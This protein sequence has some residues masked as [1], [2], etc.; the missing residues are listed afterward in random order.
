MRRNYYRSN[1]TYTD[2]G[3]KYLSRMREIQPH[4]GT[5]FFGVC[6][7]LFMIYNFLPYYICSEDEI[8]F[9]LGVIALSSNIVGFKDDWKKRNW[10]IS[11]Y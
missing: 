5:H 6:L 11:D 4:W 1:S 9:S 2:F 8:L 7:G 3:A 10:S